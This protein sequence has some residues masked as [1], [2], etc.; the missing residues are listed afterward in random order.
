MDAQVPLA[1]AGRGHPRRDA[2]APRQV[3]VGLLD[4]EVLAIHLAE[5]EAHGVA[6]GAEHVEASVAWLAARCAR[7]LGR[8]FDELRDALLDYV[9][10]DADDVHR[11]PLSRRPRR[12]AGS[13][14]P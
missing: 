1:D 11:G 9:D 5:E 12:D 2:L 3:V 7:V 14:S 10:P 13:L 4:L 8:G 6:V